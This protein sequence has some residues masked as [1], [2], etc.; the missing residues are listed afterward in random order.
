MRP[1]LSEQ[2]LK[3]ALQ[4]SELKGNRFDGKHL[5]NQD[6]LRELQKCCKAQKKISQGKGY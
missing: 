4:H 5:D 1:E 6:S 2:N 3:E